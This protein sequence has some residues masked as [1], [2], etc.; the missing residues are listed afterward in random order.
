MIEEKCVAARIGSTAAKARFA[1]LSL[2]ERA[3][4]QAE[5]IFVA[6]SI[7]ALPLIYLCLSIAQFFLAIFALPAIASIFFCA[8]VY[9]LYPQNSLAIYK[10]LKSRFEAIRGVLAAFIAKFIVDLKAAYRLELQMDNEENN[11]G[12]ESPSAMI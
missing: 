11:E 8:F 1:W 5:F 2:Y 12:N 7:F 4:F 3:E 9:K 6:D 10:K